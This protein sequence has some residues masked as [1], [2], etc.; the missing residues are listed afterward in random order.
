[1]LNGGSRL[2][3]STCTMLPSIFFVKTSMSV[4]VS[5]Y[6]TIIP[7]G[8]SFFLNVLDISCAVFAI[9]AARDGEGSTNHFGICSSAGGPDVAL[10]RAVDHAIRSASALSPAHGS[11]AR[12]QSFG[13]LLTRARANEL[14]RLVQRPDQAQ[15]PGRLGIICGGVLQC[16]KQ[17]LWRH[18]HVDHG[19]C[20]NIGSSSCGSIR[21]RLSTCSTCSGGRPASRRT[22]CADAIAAST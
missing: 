17:H 1:M 5:P 3:I 21:M 18:V 20:R 22:P 10:C 13:Q 15:H 11:Q 9:N 14:G 16:I 8:F 12:Q 7:L 4:S 6:R 19:P 2:S